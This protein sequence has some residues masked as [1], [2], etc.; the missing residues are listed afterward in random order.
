MSEKRIENK[1]APSPAEV[2]PRETRDVTRALGS[3]AIKGAQQGGRK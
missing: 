1:E 2:K 3:A